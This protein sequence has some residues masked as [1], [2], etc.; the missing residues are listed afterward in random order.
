MDIQMD[1]E[2]PDG[3]R[4]SSMVRRTFALEWDKD[5]GPMWMNADNL[6]SCLPAGIKTVEDVTVE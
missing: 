2:T 5:L 1:V 3:L 4:S 6:R